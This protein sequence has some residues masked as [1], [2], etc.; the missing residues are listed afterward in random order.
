MA[1]WMM[2][3]QVLNNFRI[4][5]FLAYFCL[6]KAFFEKISKKGELCFCQVNYRLSLSSIYNHLAL[7]LILGFY[8]SEQIISLKSGTYSKD[9]GRA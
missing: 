3:K 2:K 7:N 1:Q 6:T 4:V 8:F 9:F 5:L